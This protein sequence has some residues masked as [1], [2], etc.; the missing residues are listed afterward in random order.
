VKFGKLKLALLKAQEKNQAESIVNH[1]LVSTVIKM[2]A[3]TTAA[4]A[5]AVIVVG[6]DDCWWWRK[7][8]RGR[9]EK[10]QRQMQK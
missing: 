2:M 6:S 1:Y 4:E 8:C 3:V 5:A 10:L 7:C 9:N